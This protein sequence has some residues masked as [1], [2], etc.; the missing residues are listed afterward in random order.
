M[1]AG[2]PVIVCD[3]DDTLYLERD[4][5]RSGQHAVG[6]WCEANLQLPGFADVALRLFETGQRERIFNSALDEL[7]LAYDDALI[8]QMIEAYRGHSPR[9]ELQPDARRFLNRRDSLG[10]LALITDGFRQAQEN[11]I[12]ALGLE[13]HGFAPIV[14]TDAWGRDYW[15]PHERAYRHVEQHFGDWPGG[16]VYVADNAAKDFLAPRRLGWTTVQIARD[17]GLHDRSP[18]SPDHAPHVRIT[19]FDDLPDALASVAAGRREG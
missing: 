16:F 19:S 1:P 7:G 14:V 2:A 3:L 15:K 17:G 6:E 18:P 11:K 13:S 12:A 10:G 8:R 9:I 4:Y 5:V